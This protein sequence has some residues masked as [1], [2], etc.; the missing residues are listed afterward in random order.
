MGKP[1][2]NKWDELKQR[3]ST[4]PAEVTEEKPIDWNGFLIDPDGV[5]SDQQRGSLQAMLQER[6][7]LQ[8]MTIGVFFVPRSLPEA[9]TSVDN[10]VQEV[11]PLWKKSNPSSGHV[12]F[13]WS[14]SASELFIVGGELD[15]SV[16]SSI[17]NLLVAKK[18]TA[19]IAQS[20]QYVT[21]AE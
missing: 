3:K 14:S 16:E 17:Q 19:A 21:V 20:I 13:A 1:E 12:F 5:L 8:S 9:K 10:Y 6:N 2:V 18:Y 7:I 15:P 4:K 11:Y